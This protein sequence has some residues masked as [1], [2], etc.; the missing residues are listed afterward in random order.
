MVAVTFYNRERAPRNQGRV[1]RR[2]F[3]KALKFAPKIRTWRCDS[4]ACLLSDARMMGTGNRKKHQ[5]PRLPMR[6]RAISLQLLPVFCFGSMMG[7]LCSH[8][9]HW[10]QFASVCNKF[11]TPSLT[12]KKAKCAAGGNRIKWLG[13]SKAWKRCREEESTSTLYNR[14]VL[15]WGHEFEH[16]WILHGPLW[17]YLLFKIFGFSHDYREAWAGSP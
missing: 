1:H 16:L 11:Y 13:C 6:S 14:S 7:W 17:L 8:T 2:S 5:C 9:L 3:H 15:D 10:C 12:A 4:Q